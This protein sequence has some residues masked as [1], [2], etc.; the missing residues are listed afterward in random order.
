MGNTIT[1]LLLRTLALRLRVQTESSLGEA[2]AE[3]GILSD[4]T[5]PRWP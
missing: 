1:N 2:R 3:P 4:S 5:V